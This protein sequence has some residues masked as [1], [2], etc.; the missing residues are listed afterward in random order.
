[1]A[2]DR[3]YSKTGEW[4]LPTNPAGQGEGSGSKVALPEIPSATEKGF[5]LRV[6][7]QPAVLDLT[8]G[9]PVQAL[10]DD[11]VA[12]ILKAAAARLDRNLD[13]LRGETHE[14]IEPRW[15]NIALLSGALS[16]GALVVA[17]YMI[18]SEA[19]VPHIIAVELLVVVF[20]GLAAVCVRIARR[21][22]SRK[23][24]YAHFVRRGSSLDREVEELLRSV[25]RDLSEGAGGEDPRSQ[26]I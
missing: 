16:A 1:M 12:G 22:D 5:G 19:T 8:D 14:A 10:S 17:V 4:S 20:G 11:A 25:D 26:P 15:W 9:V 7:A 18:V 23:R 6:S 21:N 2:D 3:E 13:T 24:L